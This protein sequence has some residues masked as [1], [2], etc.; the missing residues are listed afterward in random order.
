MQRG[1]WLWEELSLLTAPSLAESFLIQAT[2]SQQRWVQRIGARAGSLV[3]HLDHLHLS[4][5]DLAPGL[6]RG[7]EVFAC[8]LLFSPGTKEATEN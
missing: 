5:C 2:L 7:H 4:S 3:L 1:R 8:P 6:H